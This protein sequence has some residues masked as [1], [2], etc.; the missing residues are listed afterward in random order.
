M[1][2]ASTA[3]C[4]S[5]VTDNVAQAILWASSVPYHAYFA[6]MQAD[7]ADTLFARYG[8]PRFSRFS[9]PKHSTTHPKAA[10]EV[11]AP[12]DA[13][14]LSRDR[15]VFVGDPPAAVTASGC[16]LHSGADQLQCISPL[17]VSAPSCG[18]HS[19]ADQLQSAVR[20]PLRSKGLRTARVKIIRVVEAFEAEVFAFSPR[21]C[22]YARTAYR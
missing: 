21:K 19:G 11:R 13:A 20:K 4:P 10:V 17:T 5:S 12:W 14:V 6:T 1:V 22:A 8:V 15:T 3:Q 9:K 18:L 16:G 2:C 7:R